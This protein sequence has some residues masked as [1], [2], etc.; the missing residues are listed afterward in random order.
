MSWEIINVLLHRKYLH[1]G[2]STCQG[3]KGFLSHCSIYQLC[4]RF[5]PTNHLPTDGRR[6]SLVTPQLKCKGKCKLEIAVLVTNSTDHAY[7]SSLASS[8]GTTLL[9][10]TVFCSSNSY[11]L[12]NPACLIYHRHM[13]FKEWQWSQI[14]GFCNVCNRSAPVKSFCLGWKTSNTSDVH[15]NSDPSLRIRSHV[16][17]PLNCYTHL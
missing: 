5:V 3:K 13:L 1:Q 9:Y 12:E 6:L 2:T 15:P 4:C 8:R 16:L 7:G 14:R 11:L 10:S 17:S